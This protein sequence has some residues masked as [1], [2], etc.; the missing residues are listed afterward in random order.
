MIL[1]YYIFWQHG[2]INTSYKVGQEPC[3]ILVAFILSGL[4]AYLSV[5]LQF[6]H[7]CSPMTAQLSCHC[8][9][10]VAP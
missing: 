10:V 2:Y 9:S 4:D 3:K 6:L 8:L 1:E 5:K 7:L